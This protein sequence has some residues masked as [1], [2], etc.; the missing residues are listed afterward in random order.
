MTRGRTTKRVAVITAALF[1]VP[2]LTAHAA[3]ALGALRAQGTGTVTASSGSWGAV[4]TT[5]SAAPYGTGSL[6]LTYAKNGTK[7]PAPQYAWLVN[8]GTFAITTI[9]T[10]VTSTVAGKLETCSTTWNESTGACTGGTI[11]ILDTNA[12][13]A[14]SRAVSLAAGA[15][16][17]VKASLTAGLSTATATLTVS[18]AVARTGTRAGTTTT[19]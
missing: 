1:V 15:R 3:E 17:R 11:T 7:A 8:T 6:V 12:T 4:A 18:V 16:T 10:T 13:G 9:S 2:V 14:T 5:A 19:S